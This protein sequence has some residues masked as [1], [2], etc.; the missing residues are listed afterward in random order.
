MKTQERVI[1]HEL[2][3]LR[4]AEQ[5]GNV[6]K[7]AATSVS[8][9]QVSTGGNPLTKLVAS[10]AWSIPSRYPRTLPDKLRQKSSSK[11]SFTREASITSDQSGSFG[12][13]PATT[14]LGFQKL[15]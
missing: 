5:T 7:T 14:A 2:K 10:N 11:R 1:Q 8:D 4:H 15:A 13:W 6:A 3:V 12:I 9:G